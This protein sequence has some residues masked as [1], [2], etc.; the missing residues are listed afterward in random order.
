MPTT[1]KCILLIGLR[2]GGK[3]TIS[4][5]LGRRLNLPV[6]EM[7]HLVLQNLGCDSVEQA[8]AGPGQAA[9]RQAEARILAQLLAPS[10]EQPGPAIISLGGGTPT[11][12]GAAD[13]IQA[14]RAQ[15]QAIVF[16]LHAD[17]P[18][19][20]Q[21]MP[22]AS[23]RPSITGLDPHQEIDHIFANRDPLFRALADH[24]IDA[25]QSP[26]DAAAAIISRLA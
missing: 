7:D 8:W 15:E 20:R 2:A 4:R 3:T 12:P 13:L 1:P 26:G 21:R 24:I 14:A 11:A 16:Y 6:I 5:L 17:P 23:D 19:L 9:F 25:T 10:I 22:P 18:T